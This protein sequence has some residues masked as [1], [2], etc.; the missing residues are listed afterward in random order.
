MP[1]PSLSLIREQQNLVNSLLVYYQEVGSWQGA[2]DSLA[3][4][5]G[6]IVGDFSPGRSPR[7]NE[8]NFV[9]VGADRQVIYSPQ[10][11]LIGQVVST[12]QLDRLYR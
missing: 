5:S 11:S 8:N 6:P 3:G 10:Q 4:L 9:L 12:S 7:H 2:A 1:L